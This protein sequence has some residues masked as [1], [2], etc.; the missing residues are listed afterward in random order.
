LLRDLEPSL[1]L[2]QFVKD[3]SLERTLAELSRSE[4]SWDELV[5]RP[6]PDGV[7]PAKLERYLNTQEFEVRLNA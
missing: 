1:F 7:D 5:R 2:F 3:S 6:L 4:Y